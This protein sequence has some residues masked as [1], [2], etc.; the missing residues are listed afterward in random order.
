MIGGA[1]AL[2]PEPAQDR[3]GEL[4]GLVELVLRQPGAAEQRPARAQVVAQDRQVAG[5]VGEGLEQR[6]QLRAREERAQLVVRRLDR[7]DPQ[8]G[9]D[10]RAPTDLSGDLRGDEVDRLQGP[11]QQADH[12]EESVHLAVEPTRDHR[13]AGLGEPPGVF[14]ALGAERVVLGRDDDRGWQAGQVLGPQW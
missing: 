11:G 12:A 7:G 2:V 3:E 5:D 10:A 13:D 4:T 14:L 1:A 9:E 6:G 8:M